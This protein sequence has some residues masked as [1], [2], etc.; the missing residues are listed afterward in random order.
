MSFHEFEAFCLNGNGVQ[1]LRVFLIGIGIFEASLSFFT[2]L[3]EDFNVSF[4]HA[5]CTSLDIDIWML[6]AEFWAD[7]LR[8]SK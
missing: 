3:Y 4:R 6:P 8:I 7:G 5:R 1:G 2:N